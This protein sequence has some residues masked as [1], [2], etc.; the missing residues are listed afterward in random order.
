MSSCTAY[1]EPYPTGEVVP[2]KNKYDVEMRIRPD[3]LKDV[4]DLE[5]NGEI[6][7]LPLN[8]YTSMRAT[9]SDYAIFVEVSNLHAED[10]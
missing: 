7:T 2:L 6:V 4:V 3:I 9:K 10:P 8:M 1:E 5:C